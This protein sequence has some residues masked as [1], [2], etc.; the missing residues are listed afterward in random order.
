MSPK[1]RSSHYQRLHGSALFHGSPRIASR[2]APAYRVPKMLKPSTSLE[3]HSTHNLVCRHSMHLRR[4]MSRRRERYRREKRFGI[5]GLLRTMC[6]QMRQRIS[7]GCCPTCIPERT[8]R[9][10]LGRPERTVLKSHSRIACSYRTHNY[11]GH[12]R[13]SIAWSGRHRSVGS[14]GRY[15]QAQR[16]CSLAA[17]CSRLA[18]REEGSSGRRSSTRWRR[19]MILRRHSSD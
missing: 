2:Q 19:S 8:S 17:R 7:L 1:R 11:S 18:M 3:L 14:P 9:T 6:S 15:D 13:R 4:R 10:V 12:R 5:R 16:P